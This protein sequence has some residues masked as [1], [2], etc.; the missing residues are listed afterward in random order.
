MNLLSEQ[1]D[2]SYEV[3]FR[4]YEYLWWHFS[5]SVKKKYF[6]LKNL[7]G[8]IPVSRSINSGEAMADLM[9]LKRALRT[10]MSKI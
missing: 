9:R 5:N 4:I 2:T 7:G 3:A 6:P 1:D 10:S 8:A